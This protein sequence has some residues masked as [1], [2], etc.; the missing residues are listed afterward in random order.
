M[1][2]QRNG[3]Y[4]SIRTQEEFDELFAKQYESLTDEEKK[5]VSLIVEDA[6]MRGYSPA[7]EYGSSVSY[8]VRPVS[9]ETFLSDEF[10]LGSM[11][12]TL[13]PKWKEEIINIDKGSYE[14]VILGG[15]IGSGKSSAGV[16]ILARLI[17]EIS[18]LNDPQLSYGIAQ[19]DK[20]MF[21]IVSI[22]EA[23]A[24]ESHGK[25]KSIIE[26]SEY[27]QKHFKPEITDAHG[28]LFPNN[29]I[30]PPPMSNAQQTIGLNAF[31]G[32]IDESNFFKSVDTGAKKIDYM[33]QVYKSI[34]D[35]MQSRFM[36]NGRLPGKLIM[37][38]SKGNVDS[39]TE[40]R[41]RSSIGDPT[42]YVSENAAYDIQPNERFSGKRFK[43]AVGNE[44]QV[45]RILGENE[46]DPEGLLVIEVPEEY[47]K[48]FENDLEKAIR[49]ISGVATVSIT[50]FIT[51]RSKIH[52]AI[53]PTRVHPFSEYIWKQ[54]GP[55]KFIWDKIAIQNKEGS[56]SPKLN[57]S[58]PRH[59]HLDLSK[60]GDRTAI[61]VAH[62]AGYKEVIRLGAEPE[63]APIFAV[64]FVLAIQAP[65]NGE[66]V[67][68]EVRKLIYDLSAHGFFIKKVSA[69][70][71]QSAPILQTLQQQG[72]TTEVISVDRVGP[73][74]VLKQALYDDRVS[75]Y[76]YQLLLDELS[77]LEKNWK[78]GKVDHPD[79]FSKDAADSLCGAIFTLSQSS[80]SITPYIGK[81]M[82]R[83]EIDIDD[84]S[85]VL[86]GIPVESKN[87][88][89]N[90]NDWKEEVVEKKVNDFQLP[91][92]MG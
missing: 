85:W 13:F 62:I 33:E 65:T 21:P 92:I 1:I 35:R 58:A 30:V 73:Y 46:S 48:S 11:S 5:I 27:F 72:Y 86:E 60:T 69:D 7:I 84:E 15:S 44:T 80:A 6:L 29:I 68:S 10:Y 88:N 53:D 74:D 63:M 61:T 8:R 64:D 38:S 51:R 49:D 26:N 14:E 52:E 55:A 17:Y 87:K 59:V 43:V 45:S 34:K 91:F 12:K 82:P 77:K 25:L 2:I 67:Y 70:S 37:I 57:P 20:I 32:L 40:R 78:T 28:M 89:Y 76:R 9:I 56:W 41:I 50:P 22:T 42:V 31:G 79:N 71:Y 83:S 16:I 47:R 66:I 81:E 24:A 75:Y 19:Y 36:R 39:F 4:Q 3:R 54:D 90:N 18:C 23:V